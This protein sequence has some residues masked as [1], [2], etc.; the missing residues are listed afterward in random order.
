MP[1]ILRAQHD[2]FALSRP[3][4]ISRGVKTQAEVVT[5]AIAQDGLVGRGEGVPYPRYGESVES[6]LAAIEGVRGA[7]EDGADRAALQSLLPPGA[8]RN[9]VDC[10][11]WDL[12]ARLAGRSVAALIGAPEP[13]TLASALTIGIDTP[14]AMADAARAV[15]SAPLLKVKVDA[16]DPDA[17]LRAVRTAAPDARMIVDPNESWNRAL[18]EAMAPLLVALRI[19]LLEQ[20]VPAG[21]DAW[22]EGFDYPIAI[23]ADEAVHVA[24]DLDVIAAR[25]SHVNVKLDKAGGL[26]AA[27]ELADAAR[28]RGMGLMTGCMISSSLSIAPALH[29]ARRS[30]FVDLD[31]PIWLAKDYPGG[32]RDDAGMM[33]PPA[34]GFWGTP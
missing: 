27:L 1:R 28:A 7:I 4:R 33:T 32:V 26:T 10:A 19:D 30:D 12:E 29:V 20:P 6:A 34:P 23:C 13:D 11:L 9:A 15:S 8:A 31:G 17:Q 18:L 3:F 21:D 25:Y 14:M 2:S 5:V 16:T 22:L 24:A